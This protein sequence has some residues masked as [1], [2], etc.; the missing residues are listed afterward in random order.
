MNRRQ[1][2]PYLKTL[3][4]TPENQESP[5]HFLENWKTLQVCFYLRNHLFR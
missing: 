2:V 5:I 4:L 3:S 1:S